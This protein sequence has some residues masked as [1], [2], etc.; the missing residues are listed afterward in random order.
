MVPRT[1]SAENPVAEESPVKSFAAMSEA[2]LAEFD[3][4]FVAAL[5]AGDDGA[6]RASLAAGVPIY[7]AEDDTPDD[8]LIKEYSDGR[9]E[10]VSFVDGIE[11]FLRTF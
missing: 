5:E 7:Y 8:S 4:E 3:R 6:A 1:E 2:E 9:R 10:L 11:T